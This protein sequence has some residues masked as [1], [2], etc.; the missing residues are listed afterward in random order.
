MGPADVPDTIASQ[1]PLELTAAG[2]LVAAAQLGLT[3][4]QAVRHVGLAGGGP[5]EPPPEAAPCTAAARLGQPPRW[6]APARR[7]RRRLLRH[8]AHTLGADAVFVELAAAARALA[9]AGGDA[10]LE[11]WRGPAACARGAVR[12]DGYAIL[13]LRGRRFGFFLEYDRGTERPAQHLA[14]LDAYYGYRDTGRYARDYDGLPTILVVA[15]DTDAE[16]R[17]AAVGAAA[18]VGRPAPLPLLLTCEWRFR[19]DDGRDAH[20]EGLLGPIWRTPESPFR[21]AWPVP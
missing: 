9:A 12:P 14:K 1:E 7:A 8:A 5:A 2:V 20:P 16:Q 6:L 3:V 19:G 15:H 17:L 18:A 21:R 4:G 10:G 13:R 11:E